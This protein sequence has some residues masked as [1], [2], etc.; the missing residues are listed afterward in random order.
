MVFYDE[1]TGGVSGSAAQETRPPPN[2]QSE[3]EGLWQQMLA[4]MD[5]RLDVLDADAARILAL[6]RTA[7]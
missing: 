4:D 1:D 6:Y 5:R 3:F 7:A 2:E